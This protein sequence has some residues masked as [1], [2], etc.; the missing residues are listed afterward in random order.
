MLVQFSV[1]NYKTFLDKATL[2]LVATNYDKET[3]EEENIL[4]NSKFNLRLIKSAVIYGANA[5]GKSKFIDALKFMRKFTIS[6]STE[7]QISKSIEVQP[8]KLQSESE[9]DSSEFEVVF[10]YNDEMFRYGFEVNQD[11]VISEW[12]YHKPKTKEIELFYRKKQKFEFHERNF[13]KGATLKKEKLVREN[14]LLL[15]VAAQF[16]DENAKKVLSWFQELKVIS[17]LEERGYKNNT[18]TKTKDPK[19]KKKILNLL[20]AA[21]LGI[22]NITYSEFGMTFSSEKERKQFEELKE[23]MKSYDEEAFSDIKTTHKKYDINKNK[24]EDVSFSMQADESNG[25]QK[26]FFLTGTVI[27]VLENGSIL[28]A[29]ELDS[30]LH[31]N[32]VCK[33]IS[34]FNTKELNPKNAQIIFNTHDTNLLSS[35]LFRRDQIWFIE[36]DR[37]GAAKLY[38]LADFKSEV[39]KTENF[40]DNYIRGKYGAIPFLNNFENTVHF[41][42][43]G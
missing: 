41:Q 21:D 24:I 3:R 8:F 27:G 42:I 36:K 13:S 31:P 19:Q 20:K 29:D 12:L 18:I 32:L 30:K 39:R 35:G 16:N 9:K 33:L 26:F 37:Y 2:S 34:L 4:N 14:A 1:R 25:T 40:E 11:I 17:G 28:F 22:Q 15:S 6:S 43:Q 7:G 10:I 23:Q 38:S 5:S